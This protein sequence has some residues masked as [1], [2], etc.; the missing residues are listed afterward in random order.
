MYGPSSAPGPASRAANAGLD[1]PAPLL[2]SRIDYILHRGSIIDAL[3]VDL[4][5]D[6]PFRSSAPFYASDHAGLIAIFAV[7]VPE[8]GTLVLLGASVLGW[9][10]VTRRRGRARVR[11][12]VLLL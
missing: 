4:V 10:W 11:R 6:I 1:N 9:G 2:D 5:G 12:Y 8:P 3:A 7:D